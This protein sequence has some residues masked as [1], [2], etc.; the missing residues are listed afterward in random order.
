M[1]LRQWL[2]KE[3]RYEASWSI[4]YESGW[5]WRAFSLVSSVQVEE[6]VPLYATFNNAICQT[7]MK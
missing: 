4:L 2:G 6:E 5:A 3:L 1:V 7:T